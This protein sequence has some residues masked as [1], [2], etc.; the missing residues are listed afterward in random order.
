[1]LKSRLLSAVSVTALVAIGGAVDVWAQSPGV[2]EIVVTAR[3]REETLQTVPLSISAF[4]ADDIANRSLENLATLAN[5]TPG[6]VFNT[7]ANITSNRPIIRG[8]SQQ[9]RVGDEVNTA[10]FVDGVYSS[11]FSGSEVGFD[12]LQRVEV[13]RGPQ[14]AL[15]GRNSFAGAI[16]YITKK[17]G[18]TYE[19]GGRGTVGTKG[20]WGVSGYASG[21]ISEKVGA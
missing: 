19:Y 2:E 1:M 11:G 14:S 10:I 7:S 16:N 21:P 13:V 4:S 12:G 3:R 6:M 15:Y 18:D 8:L 20:K 17:P 9:T 5:A